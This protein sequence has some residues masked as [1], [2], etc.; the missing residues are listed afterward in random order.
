MEGNRIGDK[1]DEGARGVRHEACSK[2]LNRKGLKDKKRGINILHDPTT[3]E[4]KGLIRFKTGVGE[5]KVPKGR[6]S[7]EEVLS[8]IVFV[9]LEAVI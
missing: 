2:C 5:E 9:W 8:V 3:R 4:Q 6:G 1:I 7:S